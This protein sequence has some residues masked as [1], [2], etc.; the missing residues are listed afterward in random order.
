MKS[1]QP[2]PHTRDVG[3]DMSNAFPVSSAAAAALHLSPYKYRLLSL[4][5]SIFFQSFALSLLYRADWWNRFDSLF[6][7]SSSSSSFFSLSFSPF[8]PF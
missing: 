7:N 1:S 5:V 2:T 4:S 8:V 3:T 6:T